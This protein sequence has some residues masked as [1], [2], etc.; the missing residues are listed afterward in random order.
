[1]GKAMTA[2]DNVINW[3]RDAYAMEMHAVEMLKRQSERLKHYPE[4][5]ARVKQHVGESE[6]QADVLRTCLQSLGTDVSRIK[7]GA[8]WLGGNLQAIF[9]SVAGAMA[10]DEVVKGAMVGYAFEHFEI[11]SYRTLIAGAEEC[12]LAE[13]KEACTKIL[14]EEEAMQQWLAEHLPSITV[15]FLKRTELAPEKA[16]R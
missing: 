9:G 13:V 2:R 4:F 6:G 12:G 11:A 10:G 7:A 1:M 16:N 8:G 14:R 5:E 15:Q 3:L